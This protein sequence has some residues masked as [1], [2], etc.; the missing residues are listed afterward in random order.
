MTQK[1]FDSSVGIPMEPVFKLLNDS[2]QKLSSRTC[3][4]SNLKYLYL[5]THVPLIYLKHKNFEL[6]ILI[7][8]N[9]TF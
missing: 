6:N 7:E 4:I 9:F 3:N 8:F 1:K 5:Y 2:I